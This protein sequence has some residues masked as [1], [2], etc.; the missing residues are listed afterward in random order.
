MDRQ[1]LAMGILL[2]FLGLFRGLLALRDLQRLSTALETRVQERTQS[3]E[4]AQELLLKTERLNGVAILGAGLAHDLKN[5]LG[6]VR[7]RSE[8]LSAR[9]P[10]DMAEAHRD[11][12]GL[13]DAATRAESLTADL[14]AFGRD[15]EDSPIPVDLA[16]RVQMLHPLLR[17]TL[18]ASIDLVVDLPEAPAAIL[19]QP[20]RLDQLVVNLVLN[21]RDA[22][23]AGG[24]LRLGVARRNR[25]SLV[26]LTVADTGVGIPPALQSRIFEPF[27]T[28]KAPGSG[29][30]L[31]LA[32]V[33]QT[34]RQLGGTLFLASAPDQGTTFTLRFPASVCP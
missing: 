15:V 20:G 7:L 11:L 9:L 8:L 21:A 5:L 13:Q 32:S 34:V 2:T 26:E 4:A 24:I 22:M 28:T 17:A 10:A 25:E 14:M 33:Q 23:P 1:L 31:G 12:E 6:V 19:S 3:L 16:L 29:T 27:F 18:P 30:G